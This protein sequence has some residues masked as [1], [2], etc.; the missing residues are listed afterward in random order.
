MVIALRSRQCGNRR[1]R[2]T[3]AGVEARFVLVDEDE[4]ERVDQVGEAAIVGERFVP[5]EVPGGGDAALAQ[6]RRRSRVH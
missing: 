5:A 6:L 3:R 2:A 4:V 1:P